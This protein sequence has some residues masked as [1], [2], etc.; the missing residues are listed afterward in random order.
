MIS[1]ILGLVLLLSIASTSTARGQISVRSALSD[2]Q[3]VLPDTTYD[4]VIQVWNESDEMQQAR[5]YQTDYV[6]FADGSNVYGDPGQLPRSNAAW[7]EVDAQTVSIPPGDW[8]PIN[9]RVRV[10]DSLNGDPLEGSYWS[11]IMVEAVP[12]ESPQSTLN[13]E[14]GEPQYSLLQIMRYGI[15]VATHISGTGA[16]ILELSDSA[17]SQGEGGSAVLSISVE[18]TGSRMIRPEMWVELYDENGSTVGRRDGIQNRIY[19]GTSVRQE[20]NLGELTPGNYRALII[21]DGGE[22]SVFA[23]ELNLAIN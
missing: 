15:Q 20:V 5:I 17:L 9:Y 2:D 16:S 18:N 11:M 14:T 4:G 23:A 10:P 22:E 12:T 13:P 21:L 1:R 19:P 7:T 8:V 3:T 6:F